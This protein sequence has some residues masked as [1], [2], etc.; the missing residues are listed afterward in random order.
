MWKFHSHSTIRRNFTARI[1][2]QNEKI[3][4]VITHAGISVLPDM[5]SQPQGHTEPKGKCGHSY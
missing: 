1:I 4:I 3:L 2:I 5:Y